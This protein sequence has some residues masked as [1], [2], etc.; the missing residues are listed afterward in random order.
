MSNLIS[1][2]KYTKYKTLTGEISGQFGTSENNQP[3]SNF[4]QEDES[5]IE[6]DYLA[7]QYK[8]IDGSPVSA[9]IANLKERA[10]SEM[11]SQRVEMLFESD[12][13][14]GA[15]SPLSEEKKLE[16]ATY[17][18][19][20]RDITITHPNIIDIQDVVWPQEPQ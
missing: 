2:K 8:I 10:I 13:T 1:G 19:A 4:V 16:W 9:G 15:D 18:Q 6:G 3:F 14:Q 5:Y 11:K 12:W 7:S 17:R 20:L